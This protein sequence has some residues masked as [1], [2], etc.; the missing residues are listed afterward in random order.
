MKRFY[1]TVC[2]VP[3]GAGFSL[4]LDTRDLKTPL[5]AALVM[6][7]R[8]M[9]DAVAMEWQAQEDSIKTDTMPLTR[10]ANTAIDRVAA[11]RDD[12]L[13][14][15]VAY[16]GT[17]LI[18]YYAD[19]PD[20]LVT[21]QKQLWVPYHA[22]MK[23]MHGISL[24]FTSGIMHVKQP[25]ETLAAVQDIL[26]PMDSFR[27]TALHGLTTGLG[28]FTLALSVVTGSNT[29]DQVWEAAMVDELHQEEEWGADS[30]AVD[31]RKALYMD[32][33]DTEKFLLCL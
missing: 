23:E 18:C 11:R 9:A 20:A 15:L 19:Y 10:L 28:S 4:Q 16:A 3:S 14:E 26:V 22:W 7:T 25:T 29:L 6:P 8:Q 24:R 2:V 31:K 13:Q 21:R 30:E 5:K 1:K 27:L 33:K 32:M 17:D 12:I